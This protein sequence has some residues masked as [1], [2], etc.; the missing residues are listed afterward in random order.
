MEQRDAI[1]K[2]LREI[3]HFF[4]SEN[5]QEQSSDEKKP[6]EPVRAA[7]KQPAKKQPAHTPQKKQQFY[8]GASPTPNSISHL[9]YPCLQPAHLP[10]IYYTISQSASMPMLVTLCSV[11]LEL[12]SQGHLSSIVGSRESIMQMSDTILKSRTDVECNTESLAMQDFDVSYLI[13][14]QAD[15]PL[16]L[17]GR[18]RFDSGAQ[19]EQYMH[20]VNSVFITDF[21]TAHIKE[22]V[23]DNH[24]THL[25]CFTRPTPEDA[26]KLYLDLKE[27]VAINRNIWC[28]IVVCD[29]PEVSQ[30][31][32][33]YSSIAQTLSKFSDV[34]PHYLGY[35]IRQIQGSMPGTNRLSQVPSDKTTAI[36]ARH[37]SRWMPQMSHSE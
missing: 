18:A 2:N 5:K 4:L 7:A 37:F 23:S 21:P 19:I 26:F 22:R 13:N 17:V 10:T 9:K 34:T 27:I 11:S 28:G 6:S 14:G 30:A 32:R 1:V 36:I 16:T 25:L 33:V 12:S 8:N 31:L 20:D 3:S 24:L 35:T 15:A 29:V